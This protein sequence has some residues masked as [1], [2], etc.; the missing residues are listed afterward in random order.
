MDGAVHCA[1]AQVGPGTIEKGGVHALGH[2]KQHAQGVKDGGQFEEVLEIVGRVVH[3]LGEGAVELLGGAQS[4][5]IDLVPHNEGQ[6]AG[7]HE[8]PHSRCEQEHACHWFQ[9]ERL[10]FH[11]P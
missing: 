1:K 8:S 5:W 4:L 3:C 9:Y 11:V 2:K 6:P 7:V 10:V